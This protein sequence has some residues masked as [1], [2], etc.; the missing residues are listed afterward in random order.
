MLK[1][2]WEIYYPRQ[3]VTATSSALVFFSK[4]AITEMKSQRDRLASEDV[5]LV[6]AVNEAEELL[7]QL[8]KQRDANRGCLQHL[9][10]L[11]G[12]TSSRRAASIM[13]S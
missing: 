12:A 2:I 8:K 9:N 10:S 1:H 4:E 5:S 7:E 6:A 13:K 3:M 11:I